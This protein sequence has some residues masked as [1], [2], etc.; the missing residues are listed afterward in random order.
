MKTHTWLVGAS[1]SVLATTAGSVV[2]A[3]EAPAAAPAAPADAPA[4]AKAA[5]KPG[6]KED[7]GPFAP[8]GKTGKLR[9]KAE[10]DQADAPEPAEPTEPEVKK[11]GRAG[12]DFVFGFGNMGTAASSDKATSASFIVSGS[13]FVAKKVRLGLKV[14]FATGKQTAGDTDPNGDT[15]SSTVFGNVAL[16]GAYVLPMGEHLELPITLELAL[17]TGAGDR[18]APQTD[19]G[20]QYRATVNEFAQASR[21]FEV[22]ELF[23][24]HRFGIVPGAEIEY[25]LGAV[26]AAGFT[27]IPILIRAGGLDVEPPVPGAILTTPELKLNGVGAEWRIGGEGYY[28]VL[29]G[30]IDLGARAWIT[31]FIKDPIEPVISSGATGPSPIQFVLEPSVIGKYRFIRGQLGFIWPLG[32]RAGGDVKMDGLRLDVAAVF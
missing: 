26:R 20:K 29:P 1:L 6:A 16:E 14:P 27:A 31:W 25:R 30:S 10:T 7:E 3:Q 5:P 13:Y 17:P 19:I 8:K 32:G 28:G 4:D 2:L 11:R 18:N 9:E 12:V 24:P 21:G 22:D 23:S 15:F